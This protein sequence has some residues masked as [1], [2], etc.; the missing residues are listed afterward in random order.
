MDSC[1]NYKDSSGAGTANS[2]FKVRQKIESDYE[3][4]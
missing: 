3:I 1:I 4:L 2:K